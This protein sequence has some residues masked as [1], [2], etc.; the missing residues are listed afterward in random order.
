MP[1]NR[2]LPS[3]ESDESPSSTLLQAEAKTVKGARK[4]TARSKVRRLIIASISME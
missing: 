1:L 4:I 2:G 3:E